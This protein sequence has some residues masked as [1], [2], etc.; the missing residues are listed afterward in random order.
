[1]SGL[2]AGG[3]RARPGGAG[4]VPRAAVV[5]CAQ[6]RSSR[7]HLPAAVACGRDA[8]PPARRPAGRPPSLAPRRP[9]DGGPAGARLARRRLHPPEP[10]RLLVPP[11]L[12]RPPRRPGAALLRHQPA[13]GRVLPGRRAGGRPGRAAQHD[14]LLPPAFER[15]PL[16][17]AAGP[18]P[19]R[20]RGAAA[21]AAPAV[22]D[23]RADAPGL[24]HRARR[25]GRAPRRGRLHDQRPRPRP[26]RG[27][28]DE[29]ARAEP[30]RRRA[31]LL[32]GRRVEDR[33][34]SGPLLPFPK[35]ETARGRPM[36]DLRSDTVTQP[37]PEMR[38]AM[39]EAE[40]GDDVYGE[41]PSVNRLQ[42]AA[43][44]MLGFEAA[45]WV[46]PG[47]MANESAIRI[48]TVP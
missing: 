1:R 25:S 39:T 31:T 37:T 22:A 43:A 36:I 15:S 7:P 2:A 38:R 40:V 35:R 20:R 26:G 6:R 16:P 27:P 33:L 17:R 30:G 3:E 12:R 9:R 13:L 10:A 8:S 29:R 47:V 11:P 4:V 14:G 41:D 24:H 34:R 18:E 21:R 19:G 32:P 42:D 28:R 45:L 5:L 48:L 46:P 23:G 44:R